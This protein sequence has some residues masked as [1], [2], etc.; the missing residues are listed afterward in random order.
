MAAASAASLYCADTGLSA[1]CIE[2]HPTWP[3]LFALGTYQVDKLPDQ[4]DQ[5]SD[6]CSSTP[7][8]AQ[9]SDDDDDEGGE[10]AR[11]RYIRRG[12][13][14]LH[15]IENVRREA[16]DVKTVASED[17]N[18]IL[19]M[20]W[21]GSAALVDC[22][23]SESGAATL[24]VA[25]ARGSVHLYTVQP[26]PPTTRSALSHQHIGQLRLNPHEKLCLSLDWSDRAPLPLPLPP[27]S[28]ANADASRSSTLA[29]PSLIVSQSDGMLVY[30]PRISLNSQGGLT[31]RLPQTDGSLQDEDEDEEDGEGD[32]DD[33]DDPLRPYLPSNQWEH[34]PEAMQVWRAHDH[35][36]WIAAWDC[37]SAGTVAW[38]GGDDCKLAG[39][40]M[41]TRI[42]PGGARDPTFAV[43]RGFDG[44]V[45]AIQSSHLRQHIWAVGSYDGHIRLFDARS[46]R[47]PYT[48]LDIGGGI[49]RTK[50]HP[51]DPER[52]LLG[53]MHVGFQIVSVPQGEGSE[54]EVV[55]TFEGHESLAYGC[56]WER[57]RM[58]GVKAAE[59][60]DGEGTFVAS[61][62]FYDA[63]LHVWRDERS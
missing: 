46:P 37:W 25:D 19:D 33:I 15:Q 26:T 30:V 63:K 11:L 22:S 49:W 34:R 62:S 57:G 1:D 29:D 36:A 24:A 53:C 48:S 18:A 17:T 8:G 20:K 35:E 32:E 12:R 45:T 16:V 31:S 2:F 40:D 21:S 38:S 43:K 52:L 3:G 44:G 51:H 23:R 60:E 6:S 47:R 58:P 55:K 9:H 14:T 50:W 41:R 39:W 27:S 59:A 42:G 56:D 61:C 7:A 54:M 10:A 5:P 28:S 4:Q 13:L